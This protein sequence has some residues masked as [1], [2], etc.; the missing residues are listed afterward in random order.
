MPDEIRKVENSN[1]R[2]SDLSDDE[3]RVVAVLSLE[4]KH[5]DMIVYET[6]FSLSQISGLLLVLE[7]KQIIRQL[8]GK[9]FV[10]SSR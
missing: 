7:M 10:V 9:M 6:G 5:L 2:N 3:K 8:P 1:I 4:P